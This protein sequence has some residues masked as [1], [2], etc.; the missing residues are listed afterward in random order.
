MR[1]AQQDLRT[2]LTAPGSLQAGDLQPVSQQLSQLRDQLAQERLAIA[3][4]VRAVLTPDQL[5]RV[6]QFQQRFQELRSEMRA[7]V[8]GEA[9]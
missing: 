2:K 3:L 1:G 9:N 6:A 4:E 8:E 5:A 7:L